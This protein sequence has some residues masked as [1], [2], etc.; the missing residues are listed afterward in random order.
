M[1]VHEELRSYLRRLRERGMVDGG[2]DLDA[3]A[4][5]LMGTLFAD[6]VARDAVPER[7]A[8]PPDEAPERYIT[9]FLRA[10]GAVPSPAQSPAAAAGSEA[11]RPD[12]PE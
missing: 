6:A 5:M 8:Y 12:S 4:N 7:Y 1:Q 10:I 9:L 3:A 11:V 2:W